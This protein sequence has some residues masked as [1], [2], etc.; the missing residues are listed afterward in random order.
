MLIRPVARPNFDAILRHEF[1][2]NGPFPPYL[3]A[4]IHDR[5]PDFRHISASTSRRNFAAVCQKAKIG[6]QLPI[7]T[8]LARPKT[9]LGP[10][11]LQQERDFQNAIQ[12]ESPVAALL[13]CVTPSQLYEFEALRFQTDMQVCKATSSPNHRSYHRSRPPAQAQCRRCAKYPQSSSQNRR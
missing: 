5:A 3:P 12:P 11:I 7:N 1:M 9:A 10:S 8:T 2:L 4:S 6:V 13:K